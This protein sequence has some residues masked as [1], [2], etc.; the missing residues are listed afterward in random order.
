MFLGPSG[1]DK[2]TKSSK[3][4]DESIR[5]IGFKKDDL[6]EDYVWETPFAKMALQPFDCEIVSVTIHDD[7]IEVEKVDMSLSYIPYVPNEYRPS[8]QLSEAI[9]EE[10]QKTVNL[11]NFS[12][13]VGNEIT[14]PSIPIFNK[15]K[16]YRSLGYEDIYNVSF[17]KSV[18]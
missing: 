16:R 13:P 6:P 18:K 5:I 8:S 7:K 10:R 9:N 4:P 3:Y 2:M 11:D 12:F 14:Y 15:S 17:K 1:M